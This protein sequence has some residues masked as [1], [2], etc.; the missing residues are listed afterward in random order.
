VR[1]G[2]VVTVNTRYMR[3]TYGGSVVDATG[4][5]F[6]VQ[7]LA[8]DFSTNDDTNSMIIMATEAAA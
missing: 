7:T 2:D 5:S 8:Y 6:V 3:Q 1:P 4:T